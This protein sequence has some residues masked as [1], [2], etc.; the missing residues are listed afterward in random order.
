MFDSLV[1]EI[2]SPSQQQC[3]TIH[4]FDFHDGIHSESITNTWLTTK[5][6]LEKN[7]SLYHQ[8]LLEMIDIKSHST[9]H[10][11]KLFKNDRKLIIEAMK[12]NG[13]A[14][15]Y[16]DPIFKTDRQVVLQAV[17]SYGQIIEYADKG[18]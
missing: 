14:F 17:K 7:T 2:S 12:R 18:K 9:S 5:Y 10:I 3:V 8:I 16:L 13:F 11:V 1:G 6:E 4:L 15:T